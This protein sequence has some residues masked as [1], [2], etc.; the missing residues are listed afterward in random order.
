MKQTLLQK[1][2]IRL[3]QAAAHSIID[4]EGLQRLKIPLSTLEVSIPVRMDNGSL[5]IFH[6]FRVRYDDTLGPTK[7]GIRFHPNVSLDEIQALAFWMTIKCAVIGVPFGGA[8]GGI[9]I[10]PKTLS[11]ME[12]ER[13]SRAYIERI[14]LFIGPRKDIPAPD[15]YTNARIMGWMMDEYSKITGNASPDVITGKP[16][17]LGGSEG[18]DQATGKGA[19]YCIKELER[20][21]KLNP[22]KTRVAIQGF[23][24]VGQAIAEFLH[25]DNY[26]IVAISDS[27]GGIYRDD[28]FDI[29]SIM[30]AKRD[31]KKVKAVYCEGSVCE[32]INADSISNEELLELDVD[33]LIPAALEDQIDKNNADKIKASY[34]VELANGPVTP[35]A[36]QILSE[37]NILIIPDVLANAGGVT[38]S[39]FEWVQNRCGT[40][41]SLTTVNKRLKDVMT[42]EFNTIYKF[43]ED[44]KISMRSAAYAYALNRL[45]RAIT[46]KGTY[47]FFINA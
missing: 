32:L 27:Q 22:Q 11:P 4:A 29:P 7:G 6:G 35:Y 8:K 40:C 20:I 37:K 47:N 34:I 5:E 15:I 31:T 18:R 14:F 13:L 38:V 43:M 16:I 45:G 3:D 25:K 9:I 12:L 1:S 17:E 30:K 26:K 23:G 39:Y 33:L 44:K 2:F 46:A 24:N 10:N 21:K 28:G 42:K 36:D 41:W 19:Y